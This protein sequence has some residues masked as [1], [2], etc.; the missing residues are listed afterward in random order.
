MGLLNNDF[1]YQLCTATWWIL[2]SS[3]ENDCTDIHTKINGIY[4][5]ANEAE[6]NKL[7]NENGFKMKLLAGG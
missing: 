3:K 1:T 4:L 7:C 5:E 2:L 6:I